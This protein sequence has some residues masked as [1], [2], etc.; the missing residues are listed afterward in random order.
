MQDAHILAGCLARNP[1][2]VAAALPRYED[3]VTPIARR[4]HDS[5]LSA[6][7]LI[8]G[9]NRARAHVRDLIVRLIPERLLERGIRRFVDAERPLADVPAPAKT[10]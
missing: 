4:Y 2:D 1:D 10:G 6:R 3:V 8:L 7:R 9:R 5:A